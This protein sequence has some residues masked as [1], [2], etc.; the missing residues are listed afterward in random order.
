MAKSKTR[1]DLTAI[2]KQLIERGNDAY[3]HDEFA[4]VAA[5]LKE[6]AQDER[7]ATQNERFLAAV[8]Y[9]RWANHTALIISSGRV[10]VDGHTP[11]P[12]VTASR[13]DARLNI[14]H[15]GSPDESR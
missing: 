7:R 11:F 15:R 14:T 3:T 4:L 8:L 2:T 9:T 10:S 6:I 13:H 1:A 5:G 12:D